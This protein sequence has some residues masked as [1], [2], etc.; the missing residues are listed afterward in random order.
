MLG[1][2][3]LAVII[4]IALGVITAW[5]TFVEARYNDTIAAQ[6]L[7]Y[8]SV[9]MYGLM[10][11]LSACLIAV[12]IDRWPWKAKHTGF[13]LAHIGILILILGSVITSEFGV[14]GSLRINIGERGRHVIVG[15]TDLTVYTS[16]DGSSYTKLFDRPVDFFTQSP[17]NDPIEV[18]LPNG[19]IRIVDYL[20]YAFREQKLVEMKGDGEGGAAVRFQLQNANVNLTEWLHQAGPAREAVKELGPARVVLTSRPFINLDGQNTLVLRPLANAKPGDESME[21]EIHSSKDLKNVKRGTIGPGDAVET[22]WMGIVL[23]ILKYMPKAKEEISYKATDASTPLTTSAIK[24]DYNGSEQWVGV[25]SLLKLFSDQAVFIVT[26]ANRRIDLGFDVHLK[27]FRVGRYP[28]T[29]QAASYE[30]LVEAPEIGEQLIS[31]N[32]PM[33][34]RGYT[35]YQSSF[36]EDEQGRPIAS[37]FSVNQDPGRWIKYLGSLLI[38]LGCIHLFYFKR[39]AAKAAK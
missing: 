33:K 2:I 15:E 24:I 4:I 28:G 10:S 3:E 13:V 8:H 37:V 36:D 21:Y 22:G 23:R 20:P 25:N 35:F 27:D 19:S 39:K 34:L 26:Y 16:M 14:D 17:K 31:M 18:K 6:K 1:S 5:G 7:V 32:E 38:V 29:M 30:S 11:L 12:M 9:W